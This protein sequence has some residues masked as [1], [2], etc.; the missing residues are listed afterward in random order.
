MHPGY[1]VVEVLIRRSNTGC[2]T[3]L[4]RVHFFRYWSSIVRN[5][6]ESIMD[7]N[8]EQLSVRLV[9]WRIWSS[10]LQFYK[11]WNIWPLIQIQGWGWYCS[12]EKKCLVV[13]VFSEQP[14][15]CVTAHAEVFLILWIV[16]WDTISYGRRPSLAFLEWNINA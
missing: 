12:R 14:R 15:F 10:R 5:N 8:T 6:G 3:R 11:P 4:L 2:K 16:L 13:I 9:Y 1:K 7:R